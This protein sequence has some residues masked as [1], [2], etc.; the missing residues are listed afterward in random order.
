MF[1]VSCCP[2]LLTGEESGDDGDAERDEQREDLHAALLAGRAS[3][4]GTLVQPGQCLGR[5]VLHGLH[6]R[7]DDV[8]AAKE[9]QGRL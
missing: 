1:L 7:E 2:S 3:L 8:Q 6:G 9:Q 5:H 4:L